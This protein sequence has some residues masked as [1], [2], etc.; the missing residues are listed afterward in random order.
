MEVDDKS[1]KKDIKI[2]KIMENNILKLRKHYN[3]NKIISKIKDNIN[4]YSYNEKKYLTSN[5][6]YESQP[7]LNGNNINISNLRSFIDSLL[8]NLNLEKNEVFI[9]INSLEIISSYTYL[10]EIDDFTDI[11]LIKEISQL[12]I[13]IINNQNK[14]NIGDKNLN[15]ILELLSIILLNFCLSSKVCDYIIYNTSIPENIILIIYKFSLEI[16]TLKNLFSFINE[17]MDTEDNFM[18]LILVNFLDIIIIKSLDKYL[19]IKNYEIV[20]V[21]LNLACKSLDYGDIFNEK[22]ND[23][24]HNNK[25]NFVQY[26]LDKKGFNDRLNLIVSPDFTNVKCSEL[27]KYIQENFFL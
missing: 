16:S 18:A 5:S 4:Y 26:F 23:I 10:F 19:E 9:V 20:S 11:N 7:N 27:A 2:I 12:L 24:Y 6:P 8:P 17:F 21:I 1:I 3:N 14:I 13:K 22:N 25:I 15:Y